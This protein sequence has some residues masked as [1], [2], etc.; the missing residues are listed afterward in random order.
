[1]QSIRYPRSKQLFLSAFSTIPQYS[2]FQKWIK[3]FFPNETVVFSEY[4]R[5]YYFTPIA[6]IV[7]HQDD[8]KDKIMQTKK[9]IRFDP[10]IPKHI[11]ARRSEW[12]Y[13]FLVDD[14]I[15]KIGGTRTGIRGRVSS[16]MSGHY[17]RERGKSGDCSTTNAFLYHTFEYYLK[18]GH[19]IQMWGYELPPFHA[20]LF[21]W[22]KMENITT[23]T[24]HLYENL[25][26]QDFKRNYG[27]Y[28]PW[29]SSHSTS[30]LL[31]FI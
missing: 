3:P 29:C 18:Q 20:Q 16:Y 21:I 27:R 9:V 5:Q 30:S 14:C 13:L 10:L 26:L 15:V 6:N 1:M 22:D 7:L 31:Y 17:V 23:Q 4:N 28:P 2:P 8:S 12:I 11:Y 19:Q 25:L 24:Y